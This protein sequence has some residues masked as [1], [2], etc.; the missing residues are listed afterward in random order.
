MGHARFTVFDVRDKSLPLELLGW[1]RSN[2]WSVDG[3]Q[4]VR[5]VS[6]K[7]TLCSDDIIKYVDCFDRK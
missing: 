6:D 7:P 1:S 3:I 4:T 5:V 2:G